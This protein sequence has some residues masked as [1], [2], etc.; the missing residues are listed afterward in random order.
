[1]SLNEFKAKIQAAEDETEADRLC[2][3]WLRSACESNSK[4]GEMGIQLLDL[5]E[6]RCM[7]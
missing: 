2:F 3:Y 7:P 6:R 4:E 1:M 5:V